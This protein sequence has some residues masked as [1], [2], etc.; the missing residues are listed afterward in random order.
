MF[1][2]TEVMDYCHSAH[3]GACEGGAREGRREGGVEMGLCGDEAEERVQAR[4]Y[5]G[6]MQDCRPTEAGRSVVRARRCMHI[7]KIRNL[8]GRQAAAAGSLARAY[9][10]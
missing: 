3:L 2:S 5:F 7:W 8:P 6:K 1:H 4:R 9:L 10:R